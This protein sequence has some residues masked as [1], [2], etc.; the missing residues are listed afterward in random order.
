MPFKSKNIKRIYNISL[1]SCIAVLVGRA[2]QHI[3]WDP[4]YRTILWDESL[5]K[6][7]VE[8]VIG[9]KWEKYVTDLDVDRTI[10][11]SIIAIGI[12]FLVVAIACLF[13]QYKKKLISIMVLIASFLLVLLAIAYW[14]EFFWDLPQFVELIA[15]WMSPIIFLGTVYAFEK[16][17][18]VFRLVNITLGLTFIGHG[19]YAVGLFPLPGNWVDLIINTFNCSESTA[20]LFLN[21]VG[22]GDIIAC[23]LLF[24]PKFRLIGLYYMLIWGLI[25]A[26]GRL[27]G[28]Y[29]PG[30]GFLNFLHTNL[31]EFLFRVP[32]FLLALLGI[33]LLKD[34]QLIIQASSQVRRTKTKKT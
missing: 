30:L 21:I 8:K 22:V 7:F 4:P 28:N 27:T 1:I 15:Q 19:L 14:K 25:A 29:I 3:F 18:N 24:F 12:Y 31:P 13:I 34:K 9:L 32:Q 2:W 6:P 20:K 16:N 11:N 26:L 23:L 17:I 10:Q 5:F 33:L